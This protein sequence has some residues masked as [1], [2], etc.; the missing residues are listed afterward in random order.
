M[1]M[2]SRKRKKKSGKGFTHLMARVYKLEAAKM[3][4]FYKIKKCDQST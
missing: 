2:K 4:V 1:N 3:Q